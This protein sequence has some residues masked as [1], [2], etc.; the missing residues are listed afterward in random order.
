MNLSQSVALITGGSSG[1]GLATAKLLAATGAHV[2]LV[3]RDEARLHAAL[4]EVNAAR[5]TT[6]QCCGALSADISDVD[7]ATAAVRRVAAIVDSPN[8]VIN[9]AGIV[10][11]GYVEE[12]DPA[13]FHRHIEVNYLGA[14]Y[15]T[16]AALPPCSNGA[17]ATS[18][19]SV[20]WPV[21]WGCS[22]TRPIADPNMRCAAIPMCCA[23]S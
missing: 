23:P 10:F 16:Q 8:I 22:A 12:L 9:S 11:P 6:M 7:E 19:T 14:V 3:A 5:R 1:I 4:A 20:Q 15:V 2:W 18:S 13:A 21:S 17:P